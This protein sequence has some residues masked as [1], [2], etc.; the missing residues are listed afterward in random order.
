[1]SRFC[2]PPGMAAFRKADEFG[3]ATAFHSDIGVRRAT[4]AVG[5]FDHITPT[6]QLGIAEA[7]ACS[8]II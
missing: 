8:N 4:A 2:K 6:N 5:T 1:M 7:P 3:I